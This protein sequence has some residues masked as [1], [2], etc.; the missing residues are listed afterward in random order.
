MK[1]FWL[2]CISL[3]NKRKDSAVQQQDPKDIFSM[4]IKRAGGSKKKKK[5]YQRKNKRDKYVH[6]FAKIPLISTAKA[7]V[8][9]HMWVYV[10][11]SAEENKSILKSVESKNIS[12]K[13]LWQN[14]C[15]LF[16]VC[17]QISILLKHAYLV[18][19]V[20]DHHTEVG[21]IRPI[22]Q[23]RSAWERLIGFSLFFF[24]SFCNRGPI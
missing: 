20:L 6:Y 15:S 9:M 18:L 1:K 17:C 19:K 4:G 10:N 23:T 11:L 16:G 22:L 14:R 7:I 12:W 5:N 24:H 8:W 3:L 13:Q 2:L 21:I